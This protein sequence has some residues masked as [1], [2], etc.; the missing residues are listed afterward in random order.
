[1][2]FDGVY[3]KGGGIWASIYLA[4]QEEKKKTIED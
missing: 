2:V 4:L 3:E 1:M